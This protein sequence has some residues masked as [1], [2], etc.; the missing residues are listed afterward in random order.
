[1]IKLL[2]IDLI[3]IDLLMIDFLLQIKQLSLIK[4]FQIVLNILIHRELDQPETDIT[5][6]QPQINSNF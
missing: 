2:M 5:I 1:M 6:K 3:M 4:N